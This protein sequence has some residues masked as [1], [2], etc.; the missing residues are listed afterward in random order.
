M[1][2]TVRKYPCNDLKLAP[3][4]KKHV[5]K[6]TRL[7]Y[8]DT[9]MVHRTVNASN[10]GRDPTTFFRSRY[11]CLTRY[12]LILLEPLS[13][14]FRLALLRGTARQTFDIPLDEHRCVRV[15]RLRRFFF[16]KFWWPRRFRKPWG[17]TSLSV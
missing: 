13:D 14:Q 10:A 6:C 9:H 17:V 12:R 16:L 4:S 8:P 15:Q 7:E 2:P 3:V 11:F 1:G 5:D